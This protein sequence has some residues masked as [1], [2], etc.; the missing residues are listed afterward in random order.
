MTAHRLCHAFE[1]EGY[2]GDEEAGIEGGSVGVLG[3]ILHLDDGPDG[4]EARPTGIGFV[5]QYPIDIARCRG[6]S[7]LDALIASR[8]RALVKVFFLHSRRGGAVEILTPNYI[9]RFLSK[10]S[11]S[12]VT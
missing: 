12:P 2:G 8:G 11:L 10:P 1:I 3:V 6:G 7:R 9:H 5:G 4:D